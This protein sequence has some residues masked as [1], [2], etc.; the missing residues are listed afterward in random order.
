MLVISLIILF[1]YMITAILNLEHEDEI[2]KLVAILSGFTALFL[3]FIST[4]VIIKCLLCILIL[5]VFNKIIV[6]S[7]N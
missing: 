4:P 5:T 2:H 3:L 6:I 1:L 7:G